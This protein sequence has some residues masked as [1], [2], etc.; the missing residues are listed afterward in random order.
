MLFRPACYLPHAARLLVRTNLYPLSHSSSSFSTQEPGL[1]SEPAD[2]GPVPAV[3]RRRRSKAEIEKDKEEKA[4]LLAKEAEK[5]RAELDKNFAKL[6]HRIRTRLD[7]RLKWAKL[8]GINKADIMLNE[9]IDNMELDHAEDANKEKSGIDQNCHYIGVG[10][11]L[12]YCI[13]SLDWR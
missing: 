7:Q 3:R 13:F 2:I 5:E 6:K 11:C 1:T 10:F 4:I 12:F 9:W 8:M